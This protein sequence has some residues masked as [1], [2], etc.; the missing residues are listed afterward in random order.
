MYLPQLAMNYLP[1]NKLVQ[2]FSD[3]Q[4]LDEVVHINNVSESCVMFI[5]D[6]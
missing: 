1:H 2:I 3:M 5:C 4:G 6:Y